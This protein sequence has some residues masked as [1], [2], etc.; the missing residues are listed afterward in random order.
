MALMDNLKRIRKAAGISQATLAA[1]ANVS[2]QLISRLESGKDMTTKKLPEIARALKVSA[3]DLDENYAA[4]GGTD[5]ELVQLLL[6]APA[7]VKESVRTLIR[8]Q[9]PSKS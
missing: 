6:Q 7:D 1:T 8:L 4:E 2:Q 3:Y 9:K 5:E